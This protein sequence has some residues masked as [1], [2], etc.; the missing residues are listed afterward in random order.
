MQIDIN[1]IN[2][3]NIPDIFRNKITHD[4]HFIL[5]KKIEDLFCIVLF[6]SLAKNSYKIGSDVDLLIITEQKV[7][8]TEKSDIFFTLDEKI[9]GVR[10]DVIFYTKDEL[11]RSNSAMAKNLKSEGLILWSK[12]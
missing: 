3:L 12:E 11:K 9:D 6:G 10:T 5:E 1:H 4:I 7:N 2:K 8:Q